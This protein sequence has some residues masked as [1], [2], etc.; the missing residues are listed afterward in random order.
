MGK[1][2]KRFSDGSTLYAE[3]LNELVDAINGLDDANNKKV[4]KESGKVLSSND[5]T[6]TLKDKLDKI[7]AGAQINTVTSVAGRKGAVTLAKEDVGLSKVDNTSDLEKPVSNPAKN[8]FVAK[9]T[10]KALSTNDFSDDYKKKLDNAPEFK[11]NGAGDMYLSDDGTYKKSKGTGG[12]FYDITKQ[13]PLSSGYYT[14]DTAI[15]ALKDAAI[16]DGDK[17]GIII[18]FEASQGTWEEYR[19]EGTSISSFLEPSAWNKFGGADSVKEISLNGTTLNKDESGRVNI[20]IDEIEV[21]ESLDP[22]STNPVQNAAVA[23][24]LN[25]IDANTIFGANAELSDDE[26]TVRLTLTNKSGAEVVGVD[27]PAGGGGGTGEGGAA[28]KIVIGAMVDKST[29]KEGDNVLLTYTYDHQY[30][31]GDEK[32]ESTGQKAAITIQ[33]KRGATISFSETIQEVSKGSYTLD[34]TKYLLVGTSDIYIIATTTDP[35]TGKAQKKQAYVTVKSVSLTLTSS[36][37]LAG[38]ISS[39]GYGANDTVSVP[40]SV[41]GTGTK[42]VA[43]YVDGV[44]QNAHTI[45]RS[46]TTN[47]SF[48]VSMSNLSSGRHTLQMVAE[49]E[50]GDNLILK[51]ESIY[52]DILKTGSMSPFVG[53]MMINNDGRIFDSSTHLSPTFEIGQYEQCRFNFVAYDPTTT[54]ANL[55]ILRDE[56]L[57]QS[58]SV[59][60][61][62]QTYQNRF[63]EQ[64]LLKM[65]FVVGNFVSSFLIDVTESG[66]DISESTYGMVVKLSPSGRSNDESNP[67]VWESGEAKTTFENVDFKTSGW[68]DGTLRLINGAKINIDYQLFKQDAGATGMTVEME[69]RVTNVLERNSEVVSCMDNGKGLSITTEE[70]SIKTGTIIHYINEDGEDTSREV[71][72]GTKFAPDK[73]L[74]VA[75]V[76]SKRNDGRLMELYVNGNRAGADIYDNSYYFQQDNPQGITITSEMADVEIKNIRIYNRALSDDEVLENRM[77]DSESL[78]DMMRL[79]E[80]NDVLGISG[81][82]D[83][84]KLRAKG[85]GVMRIVRQGGLDELNETN[86]KST[87]FLADVYFYSPFGK[88]YDFV[89][90]S[91]YIRI[92]GTSSTKYP[93]KNIRIYMSKGGPEL[94]LTVNGELVS[95]KKYSMQPGA[96]EMNLFC[97]KSDYSDSSMTSNTGGAKLYNDVMLDMGLMTPPQQYQYE[98]SGG[99]LNAVRVRQAI[100]GFPIDIYSAESVEGESTYYGQYNFNNEK[101]KSG[102]LFGMEGV[103]GFTPECPM[104]LE[105]LNNGEGT[106]LF[107]SKSDADLAANF[108]AGL[109]INYPDDV[110]WAGMNDTQ[111]AALTRLFAWIRSCV[112]SGATAEDI[113]TFASAKFKAE[114]SQYFNVKHAIAYYIHTD[115]HLSVDQR[116]KNMLLRT[117][118]GKIWYITYYDGDTQ[119]GKRND[120][121]LVYDYTTDRNTWDAEAGKYAFEGRESWLWNLILANLQDEVKEVASEYRSKMTLDRVLNMLNVEQMGNWSDRVYNK[122][123]YIKYIRPAMVET[124]GKKWPFIYAL[125]GNNLAH[126]IYLITN[127]FALLD[128]KYGT[129]N[130]TSDNIDLY[131]ARGA[132]DAAD[133]VKVT[134]N[135]VYAFGYGTNNSPNIANTGIVEGGKVASLQITG[136]YTVNDPLRIY[137]AS[138]MRVLDMTGAADRLKNGFDLGKCTVLREINLQSST[139]G[140]TGWWL[141]LGSCKQLRKV[142]L[143]NQAQAKTGSNTSTELDF[144]NQNKL[145]WLDTRGTKV[146]SITFS[147]GAPLSAAYLPATLTVLKLENLGKLLTKNLHLEGYSNVKTFIVDGCP[148]IDWESILSLCTNVERIR[149]T[150]IDREGNE[151]WLSKFMSIGGVDA[152][153]NAT[154]TCTLVGTYKLTQYLADEQFEVYKK[155]FPELNIIQPEYTMIEFDDSVSDDRNITNLDN[156]TGYN[157][158]TDY[159]PS[160]HIK[161]I[162][163]KRRRCL[164]KL[165]ATNKMAIYPLHNT[166]SNYYADA[167][168]IASATPAKLDATEG[169]VWMDEPKYWYKGINDYLNDKKYSCF[170][171]LSKMPSRPDSSLYKIITLDEVVASKNYKN[172]YKLLSNFSTI[173]ASYSSD[174]S[175]SVCQVDVSGYKKVRFPTVL[176]TSLICSI[177]ADDGG[178]VI[179]NI[180]VP[181]LNNKFENGMYLIVDVPQN[182]KF[183]CFTVHNNAEF[184]MV[185]L[186]NSDKIEDM[187]PDWVC[188]ERCLVGV[189]EAVAKGSKLYSAITGETSVASLSKTDMEHYATQRQLQL[190]DY[191]MHKDVANLFFAHYGRR[192]SQ[193]QCGYGQNTNARIIGETSILGMKDT[194]NQNKAVEYSWYE[195]KN[196]FGE[197]TYVRIP[198]SNCLGYEN[199]YGNKCEWMS[200]VGIPNTTAAEQLKTYIEMP[201]GSTRKVKTASAGTYYAGTHHQKY[202]DV[203]FVGAAVASTTTFYCDYFHASTAISRA[204]YRSSYNAFASGGVS[205]SHGGHD[206][207]HTNPHIGSR[208][209]F[210]GQIEESANVT[211][212]KALTAIA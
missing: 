177:F 63:T 26:S 156:N 146:Q 24:K 59:P 133:V 182:A 115:Y 190:V 90:R 137:G 54:P 162:M 106:C 36:Y 12:G 20:T 40:Y 68:F 16:D 132:S 155:H 181:T 209:A 48:N 14:K 202:M 71:K 4:D 33:I 70:A 195:S 50:A 96:I 15:A 43:L 82:V 183:L 196:E 179:Q 207:S 34:L 84:D 157:S 204:F 114:V 57:V 79:Y 95:G 159:I 189:F 148:G 212:Y 8:A 125:Q 191:E 13:H 104:T 208:L 81:D 99:D 130:F 87:D 110:K 31:S 39:G 136:A 35:D 17:R 119:Y 163:S 164:G 97:M 112:P 100:G 78:D 193:D 47:S 151:A 199:W 206:S 172:K 41:N 121:F 117:W 150:G 6:K 98:K 200:K 85:K 153:G 129:S 127:R 138:R 66:I 49:M 178:N 62:V 38:G 56:T 86:N 88:E 171:S 76:I 134:A 22:K 101:S 203:L 11:K 52:I 116:A 32:G 210:R 77:V 58:V 149:I 67:A 107:Q 2:D 198:S 65:K 74:K 94:S 142:N 51:S 83:L 201:D 28:T 211:A 5:F 73:W 93:S 72:I 166:N 29:I 173:T 192:D 168:Y 10:G 18:T 9:E 37:N 75:F 185:L 128:A 167:Q 120:C 144:S 145:E 161:S 140:S 53:L 126:R 152:D 27:L 92:Q 69:Y 124:Y 187:E 19:F 180:V 123:G 21:D 118:D 176:G 61:A 1:I 135:E 80:E 147:K 64:G 23:A 122:S 111:R 108:D 158:G 160:G 186:S 42:V 169:D 170:S 143:R 188:H 46:G 109:E 45:T 105:T 205:Y 175:Y 165:I 60:R 3:E 184:D 25:E 131:M 30:S 154:D 139:T 44:Q 197:I 141:N 174:A 194:V 55:E 102:K 89:L 103:S 113:S 7:E 91:C